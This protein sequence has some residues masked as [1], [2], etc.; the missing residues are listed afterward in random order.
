M[1]DSSSSL[2]SVKIDFA[3]SHEFFPTIVLWTLAILLVLIFIFNGIPYLRSYFNKERTISLSLE[4]VDKI[5]LPGTLILTVVYFILMDYI[6]AFFPN[7]G[8]G[9]WFVSIPFIF[10]VS[11]L[12]VH[13]INRKKLVAITLNAI[14][15]PSI[16]WFLLAKIFSITLP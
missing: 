1:K 15:A 9:F 11:I 14:I 6:G 16:A 8:Y 10:L 3:Q 2:L 5:R 12:Y 13:N 7:M 4:H